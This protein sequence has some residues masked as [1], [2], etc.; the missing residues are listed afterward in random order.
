M[1]V[2]LAKTSDD[3]EKRII[4]YNALL[5]ANQD[6]FRKSYKKLHKAISLI[7][8]GFP[9]HKGRAIIDSAAYSLDLFNPLQRIILVD[10]T[11]IGQMSLRNY[12]KQD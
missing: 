8:C 11:L 3:F 6:S 2:Q 12:R 1:E 7:L 9:L 10:L 5:L 4:F